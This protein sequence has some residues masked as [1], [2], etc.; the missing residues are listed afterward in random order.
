M[1]REFKELRKL[2]KLRFH[3]KHRGKEQNERV[4]QIKNFVFHTDQYGSWGGHAKAVTFQKT[5]PK[6]PELGAKE[7]TI[8]EYFERTYNVTLQYW[9]LPL[10]Q[11]VKGGIFPM[12]LC[13]LV[14]DQRYMFKLDPKQVRSLHIHCRE[15]G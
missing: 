7:V 8:Y 3:V 11:T 13:T 14:P 1:S 6:H 4:Y 12:E 2:H 10:V 5:D 15:N 9:K